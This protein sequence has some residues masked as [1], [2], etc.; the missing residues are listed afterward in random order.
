MKNFE[1]FCIT[2]LIVVSSVISYYVITLGVYS[3]LVWE[4]T[5]KINWNSIGNM[6]S[7]IYVLGLFMYTISVTAF[8]LED[9]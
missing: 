6:L 9:I 2:L 8:I 7:V 5:Y 4:L 1:K 3:L